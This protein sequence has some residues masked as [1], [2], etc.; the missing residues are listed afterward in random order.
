METQQLAAA[1]NWLPL[2]RLLCIAAIFVVEVEA[3]EIALRNYYDNDSVRRSV[4]API[5]GKQ[6]YFF[7][8]V[9]AFPAVLLLLLWSRLRAYGEQFMAAARDHDWLLPM[10]LQ[11][12]AWASFAGLTYLLSVHPGLVEGYLVWVFLAWGLALVATGAL[13]LAALAP[14]EFWQALFRQEKYSILVAALAAVL[15]NALAEGLP[16]MAPV[17]AQSALHVAAAILGLF[18]EPVVMYE[19]ERVLGTLDFFVRVSDDC[20]GYEGIALVTIFTSV[21]LWLFRQDFRFPRVLWVLP[22]GIAVIW[23]FNVLRIVAL[24]MLGDLYSPSLAMAGFHSNAGWI[25][26]IAVILLL[27]ALLHRIPYFRVDNGVAVESPADAGAVRAADAMVIPL[28]VLLG[29]AL[30][31][32]AVTTD[33]DWAYP[34]KVIATAAALA[35]F[36]KWYDFAAYRPHWVA[37]AIGVAVF[38]LWMAL[39]QPSPEATAEF[40][41]QLAGLS[42]SM[43]VLWLLFRCIGATI[44]V[45]LVEELAFRGYLLSRLSG[46][47]ATINGRLPFSVIGFGVSSLLFG[48]M[49]SDWIAGTVAGAAYALARYQRG[50]TADAIVAHMTTNGLLC[51]YVLWSGDWSYW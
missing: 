20:A 26:F 31:L 50:E 3:V 51:A 8:F 46:T 33:F 17:L 47:A 38:G 42:T 39:V 18:Y 28:L 10:G 15:T 40:D 14:A 11:L 36:W 23:G 22:I 7:N 21:Y 1:R 4:W 25:A 19:P 35:W 30:L 16:M 43:L 44:T 41:A 13:A 48:L 5:M 45:P 12:L 24:I 6:L 29:A 2:I 9:I 27:L 34:I 37:P 32:G 49:H